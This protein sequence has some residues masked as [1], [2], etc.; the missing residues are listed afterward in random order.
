MWI[1][2]NFLFEA[3]FFYAD[4]IENAFHIHLICFACIVSQ[5]IC[6]GVTIQDEKS[7]VY[8]SLEYK[9]ELASFC[10]LMHEEIRK[11]VKGEYQF[12]WWVC[13]KIFCMVVR[14]D[15]VIPQTLL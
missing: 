15:G 8:K 5:F 7:F 13:G 6:M 12:F 3:Y 14:T 9:V 2:Q 1:W 10:I 11:N 4:K